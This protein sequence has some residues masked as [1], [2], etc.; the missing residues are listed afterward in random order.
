MATKAERI[1]LFPVKQEMK[2]MGERGVVDFAVSASGYIY[3]MKKSGL[4]RSAPDG[5]SMKRLSPYSDWPERIAGKRFSPA[6]DR[7]LYFSDR[8]VWVV[9]LDYGKKAS[10]GADEADIEEV[11]SG[12]DPITD[13]FWYPGSGYIIVVTDKDIEVSE[14]RTGPMRNVVTLYKFNSRPQGLRYDESAGALYFVDTGLGKDFT[15]SRYLY[16]IDLRQKFFD[17]IF[18]MLLKKEPDSS[19]E[20][21]QGP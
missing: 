4:Y 17:Q 11:F 15:E 10:S 14:L 3:Y 12:Q 1:V 18:N 8:K 7:F 13:V 2:K 20:K 5:T 16:K 21:R 9:T 19:Y 6:Q